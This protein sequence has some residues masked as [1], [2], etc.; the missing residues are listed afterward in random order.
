MAV[1]RYP[2]RRGQKLSVGQTV[3]LDMAGYCVP[4]SS[5]PVHGVLFAYDDADGLASVH[6]PDEDPFVRAAETYERTE[7][8]LFRSMAIPTTNPRKPTKSRW[9]W[10]REPAF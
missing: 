3:S 5:G 4:W 1:Y 7:R 9:D 2:V 10:L 8:D 6:F